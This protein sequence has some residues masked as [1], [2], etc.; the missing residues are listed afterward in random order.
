MQCLIYLFEPMN[1]FFLHFK[2]MHAVKKSN[3]FLRI[4]KLPYNVKKM[5]FVGIICDYYFF[6]W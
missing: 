2:E 5:C 3:I 1:V 4:L 6:K